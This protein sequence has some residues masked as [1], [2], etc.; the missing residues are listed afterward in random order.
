MK[1]IKVFFLFLILISMGAQSKT[2]R[3]GLSLIN[4]EK[5]KE[6]NDIFK[7]LSDK[8]DATASYWLAYTQFKTSGTLGVGSSLLKAAEGGNPWAMATLAGTHMPK[9]TTS[10]CNYLGWPCDE[11][12]VDKAIEGWEKLAEEGDGK[13]MYA[14]LYHD[15]SWWQYI[16]FYRDYRYGKL[17]DKLYENRGYTFFF[18]DK[19]WS[20]SNEDVR[21]EFLKKIAKD[22]VFLAHIK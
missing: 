17:A 15:P 6:A 3:D 16:P 9:V 13:A 21:I 5:Y 1:M 4:Q 8:G 22:G 19:F 11:K 14:L 7:I 20:G 18:D 10:Y 12:W 2:L